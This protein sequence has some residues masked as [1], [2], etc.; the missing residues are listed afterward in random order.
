MSLLREMWLW[1]LWIQWLDLMLVTLLNSVMNAIVHAGKPNGEIKILYGGLQTIIYSRLIVMLRL[2]RE[3]NG[4]FVAAVLRNGNGRLSDGFTRPVNF[5]SSLQKEVFCYLVCLLDEQGFKRIRD[6]KQAIEC[7]AI[8]C[9]SLGGQRSNS[10]YKRF[11]SSKR[12]FLQ[13]GW[14]IWLSSAWSCSCFGSEG[15]IRLE[16]KSPFPFFCFCFM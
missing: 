12:K 10:R 9:S 13:L 3:G 6:N 14:A 4:S 5:R 2:M 16:G 11:S 7:F 1:I 15:A 8:C